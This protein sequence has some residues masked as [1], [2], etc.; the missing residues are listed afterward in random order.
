MTVTTDYA[1]AGWSTFTE[2]VDT[3]KIYVSTSG[4]D[5]NDGLT[6]STPVATPAKAKTLIRDGY[7]LIARRHK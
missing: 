3:V 2:S 6:T 4:S 7:A 5:T 1:D